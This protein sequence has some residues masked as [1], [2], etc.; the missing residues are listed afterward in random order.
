MNSIELKNMIAK[1]VGLR[2]TV[3]GY[4]CNMPMFNFENSDVGY[5]LHA[6]CLT[7]IIKNDDILVT[8]HDYQS[9][10]GE[11]EE[12]NDFLFN[13]KKFKSQIEGGLVVSVEV[14]SL[15][16]VVI[17]LDN[18]V[19]IQVI[20]DNSYAHY[21]DELEQY[22]FFKVLEKEDDDENNLSPHYVVY[23]KHI[24]IDG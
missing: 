24:D 18:D 23:S 5:A 21:D 15:F 4:A 20:I 7:R 13:L 17:I 11:H 9:W 8:T 12:N 6:Q 19:T 14:N 1:I 10:D 2:L 22:R 16:D 3:I